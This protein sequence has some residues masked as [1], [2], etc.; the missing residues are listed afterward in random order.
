VLPH[1]QHVPAEFA[2]RGVL[3]SVAVDVA[4]EFGLPPVPVVAWQRA[5]LGTAVPEAAIHEHSDL[6]PGEHDV[7]TAGKL[8]M[9]RLETQ[10]PAVELA[11]QR[12]LWFRARAGLAA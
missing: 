11:A 12:D 4:V 2:E 1:V 10:T 3:G 9:V 5:V 7:R 6:R 8:G